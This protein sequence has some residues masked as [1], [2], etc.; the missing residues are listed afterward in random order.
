MLARPFCSFSNRLKCILGSIVCQFGLLGACHLDQFCQAADP[1]VPGA[2]HHELPAGS[3]LDLVLPVSGP[4]KTT[5][6]GLVQIDF[7]GT[8]LPLREGDA[9][10]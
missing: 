9:S 4:V 8:E 1:D 2:C 6:P 5:E 3:E 10:G 7:S